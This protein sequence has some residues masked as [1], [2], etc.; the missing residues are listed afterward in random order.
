MLIAE[1]WASHRPPDASIAH[2]LNTPLSRSGQGVAEQRKLIEEYVKSTGK[3]WSDACGPSGNRKG[4]GEYPPTHDRAWGKPLILSEALNPKAVIYPRKQ[5]PFVVEKAIHEAILL[6]QHLAMQKNIRIKWVPQGQ[7][8]QLVVW[9]ETLSGDHQPDH[10]CDRSD[11]S[12][13]E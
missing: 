5:K 4:N 2:E 11:G 1:K 12:C 10:Q 13:G 7:E 8:H 9:K 3:P 6:T